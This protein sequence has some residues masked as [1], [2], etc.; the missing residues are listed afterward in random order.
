MKPPPPPSEVFFFCSGSFFTI[1]GVRKGTPK[2]FC[3]KDFAE[4]SGELS[5]AICLKTLVL[6]GSALELFRYFF[7]T[8]CLIFWL[9]GSF[10]ALDKTPIEPICRHAQPNPHARTGCGTWQRT[11]KHFWW[12]PRLLRSGGVL[13]EVVCF[14]K[15]SCDNS[16]VH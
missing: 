16:T 8:V 4:L 11:F 6:L 7:G 14:W 1:I 3:D 15:L 2:N 12:A 10:S 13:V 5:G 9:W